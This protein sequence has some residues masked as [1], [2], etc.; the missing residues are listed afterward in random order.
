VDAAPPDVKLV[1]AQLA[2]EAPLL[3]VCTA[4]VKLDFRHLASG[5]DTALPG[6]GVA[7]VGVDIFNMPLP[8]SSHCKSSQTRR[9][10]SWW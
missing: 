9:A 10:C 5:P 8:V 3:G 2:L 4:N 1:L 7:D 6:A